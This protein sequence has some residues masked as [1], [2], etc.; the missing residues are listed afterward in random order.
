MLH[1]TLSMA[2]EKKAEKKEVVSKKTVKKTV[3]K[4]Q[5][6]SD[7]V[8]SGM[9]V[10][11]HEKIID[12]TPKGESRERI[13]IFKGIVLARKHRKEPGASITVRKTSGGVGVEKIFP[14]YSPLVDRVVIEKKF[15]TR[16]A[17]LYFLRSSKKRLKE[18]K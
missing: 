8:R 5:D 4:K 17:K 7:K 10:A 12:F 3:K 6:D 2:K 13:Q 11:V 16:R 9:T 1:A 15:K 14:L 18:I